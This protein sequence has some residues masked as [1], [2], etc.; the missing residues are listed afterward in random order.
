MTS[1]SYA[2]RRPQE[3]HMAVVATWRHHRGVLV[4]R[5]CGVSS[6]RCHDGP[7]CA[8][9]RPSPCT[10][11]AVGP[12]GTSRGWI[13][14]QR[15][16]LACLRLVRGKRRVSSW[17]QDV[18]DF[19]SFDLP[20]GVRFRKRPPLGAIVAEGAMSR[21][22]SQAARRTLRQAQRLLRGSSHRWSHAARHLNLG[23]PTMSTRRT[24]RS[25][26]R[27]TPPNL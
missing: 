16:Q 23:G 17:R 2:H 20:A 25:L 18:D 10:L 14:V 22:T 8:S 11:E 26:A 1:R 27:W 21:K 5:G 6:S 19:R 24:G 12:R 7:N 9:R 4:R 13:S 3:G 15:Y